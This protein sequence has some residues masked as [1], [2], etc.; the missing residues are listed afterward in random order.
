MVEEQNLLVGFDLCN[1]YSQIAC[2]NYRTFEP[3]SICEDLSKEQYLIPTVLG[4]TNIKKEWVYGEHAI[5]LGNRG[6]AFLV[7]DI[8][9]VIEREEEI[10]IFDVPFTG[11]DLLERFLRKCFT[12][13][14]KAY[15]NESIQKIVFTVKETKSSL[16]DALRQALNNLKIKEERYF[17]QSHTRSYLLY[18]LSQRREL[19]ANDIGLFDFEES[20]LKYVQINI[21]S[22]THPMIAGISQIDFSN[23]LN[24]PMLQRSTD[25]NV[26]YLLEN[27]IKSALHNQIIS[28]IYFTGIGFEGDWADDLIASL[29]TGRKVFRGQNLY[30]KGACYGAKELIKPKI[31]EDILFLTDEVL[32]SD[33]LINAYYNAGISEVYLAKAGEVWKH[34]SNSIDVILDEEEEIEIIIRN[35]LTNKETKQMIV[36]EGILS[37]PYKCTRIRIRVQLRSQKLCVITV[38]DLGFGEFYPT[39]NRVW[40]QSVPLE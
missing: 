40:E 16:I 36:L 27:I 25:E 14:K 33:I 12:L 7:Y 2:Y 19:W 23:Q 8:V 35:A 10:S 18:A 9:G 26:R 13:L 31:T 21:K 1:D 39:S 3:E 28:T 4:V 32:E 15:P 37:E 6:E 22:N 29:C 24:G 11:V 34:F 38:K 5:E 17:I 20:G 30:V